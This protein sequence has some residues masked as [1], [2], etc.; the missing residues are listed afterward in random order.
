MKRIDWNQLSWLV[1]AMAVA[2]LWFRIEQLPFL[3]RAAAAP[4]DISEKNPPP[5]PA[6]V[7]V[8]NVDHIWDNYKKHLNDVAAVQRQVADLDEEVKRDQKALFE[9]TEQFKLQ[10]QGSEAQLQL[11]LKYNQQTLA[12]NTKVNLKRTEFAR[13]MNEIWHDHY[14]EIERVAVQIAK[15][16]KFDL[17]LKMN[18]A[19]MRRDD[20]QSVLTVV[21]RIV[22][23]RR[24]ELDITGD[25]LARLNGK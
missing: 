9:I 11:Q 22:V 4:G 18:A 12:L 25:V 3:P 5:K 17:V 16:R 21:N 2:A 7:G 19:D 15:E 1:L 24:D 10:P 6:T 13:R 14:Q 23:Y 8:L 20:T